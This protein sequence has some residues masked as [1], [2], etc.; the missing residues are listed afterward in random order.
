MALF[1][2]LGVPV[3]VASS[4]SKSFSLY[5]ERVGGLSV[6]TADA[7][8]AGRVLSQLKVTIRTIYSNPPTH[9]AAVVASVLGDAELR[10]QGEAVLEAMR[11][12]IKS[13]RGALVAELAGASRD[14]G[15][16]ADQVGMFSY[17]GLSAEQMRDLREVHGVYGTDAGRICV[18]ALNQ[19]I[20]AWVAKAIAAVL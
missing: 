16:V 12:R 1:D 15:F 19:N 17:C 18:A 8:E 10:A 7:D 3:L 13:M 9:G 11:L 2:A 4:F 20:V 6:L 14:F 5:G